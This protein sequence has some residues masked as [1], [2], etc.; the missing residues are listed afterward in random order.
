MNQF[1]GK[2]VSVIPPEYATL[3]EIW[4]ILIESPFFIPDKS[5][6]NERILN[7][8]AFIHRDADKNGFLSDSSD[9]KYYFQFF[10]SSIPLIYKRVFFI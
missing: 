4:S 8:L 10:Y 5:V 2:R 9:I 6:E 3:A 7:L 1:I